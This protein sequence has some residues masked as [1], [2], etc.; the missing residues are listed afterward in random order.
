MTKITRRGVI[1]A[2]VSAAVGSAALIPFTVEAQA[3]TWGQRKRKVR[4][5]G[6]Q[7]AYYEVGEGK[8]IVFLHGNPTSSYLWRNIIPQVQHL[9]RCIAPDLIGMGDSDKLPNSGPG[10]YSFQ[11][12]Q[13]YLFALFDELNLGSAVT[14]VIHDWGSALG[15]TWAELN[16]ARVR[17][18]AYMEAI[19]EPSGA[20]TPAPPPGSPFAILR[21]PQGEQLILAENGFVEGLISGLD[22][23]LTAEDAAEYR[24]PFLEPG[25]SRRPTLTWPREFPLGGVPAKM[26]GIVRRYSDWLAADAVIPKLFI[27]ADP[28]GILTRPEQLTFVRG[29]RKQTEVTVYGPHW[30][31]EVSPG[32]IGRALAKWIPALS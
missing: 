27:R 11:E 21:S 10:K 8:P 5:H 7:M 17:G 28:G 30:V 18:I 1:Q 9:G 3:L 23:Y 20:P 32:A 15:L 4:V 13:Q 6:R 2:A 22:L 14:L 29:F 24:R 26:Y 31:Q 12:H 19:I 25:E 16:S